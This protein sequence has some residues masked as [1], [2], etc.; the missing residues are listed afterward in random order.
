MEAR[1]AGLHVLALRGCRIEKPRKPGKRHPQRAAS[2]SHIMCSS[3]RVLVAEMVMRHSLR[4]HGRAC[5]GHLAEGGAA[6]PS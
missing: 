1:A 4:C 3:K 2:S 5:P 6:V